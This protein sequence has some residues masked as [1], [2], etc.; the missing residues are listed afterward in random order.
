MVYLNENTIKK[1]HFVR[2]SLIKMKI[3]LLEYRKCVSQDPSLFHTHTTRKK[4]DDCFYHKVEEDPEKLF[5][6]PLVQR[7]NL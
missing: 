1:H 7:N 4:E 2:C 5:S 3:K 6:P